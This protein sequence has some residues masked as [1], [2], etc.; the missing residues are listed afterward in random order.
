MNA[1]FAKP[2][3][4]SM[5][6]SVIDYKTVEEQLKSMRLAY[7]A[8]SFILKGMSEDFDKFSKDNF[9]EYDAKTMEVAETHALKHIKTA[10]HLQGKTLESIEANTQQCI[11]RLLMI[12]QR[13]DQLTAKDAEV[14]VVRKNIVWLEE[15]QADMGKTKSE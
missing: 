1:Q 9:E 4:R 11:Q 15:L 8:H 5:D 6:L 7:V 14:E 13:A 12:K 2:K 3:T 10:T